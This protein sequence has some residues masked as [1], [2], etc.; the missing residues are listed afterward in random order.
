MSFDNNQNTELLEAAARF[1]IIRDQLLNER[2]ILNKK[3]NFY[4]QEDCITAYFLLKA[5]CQVAKIKFFNNKY[6]HS[7]IIKN[8]LSEINTKRSLKDDH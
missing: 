4:Q 8:S 2:I 3:F 6:M 5:L 1:L 7:S